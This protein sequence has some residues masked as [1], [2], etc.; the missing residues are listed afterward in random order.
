MAKASRRAAYFD[1]LARC[2]VNLTERIEGH[3]RA[4]IDENIADARLGGRIGEFQE[5]AGI[6]VNAPRE[7]RA[8]IRVDPRSTTQRLGTAEVEIATAGFNQ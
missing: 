1:L 3:H 8:A 4:G 6:D 2:G 7:G 5:C